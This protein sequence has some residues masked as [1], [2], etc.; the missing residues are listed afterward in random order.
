MLANMVL[1]VGQ[2][3]ALPAKDCLHRITKHAS[4]QAAGRIVDNRVLRN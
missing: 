3:I 2:R 4:W 1:P